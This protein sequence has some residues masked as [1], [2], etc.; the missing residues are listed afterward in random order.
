MFEIG[1]YPYIS[2][3]TET[4]GLYW[5]QN[6]MFG[7][8]LA[9]PDGQACYHDIRDEPERA[10][11]LNYELSAYKGRIIFHNASFDIK[12]LHSAGIYVP[13]EL[14]DDTVIRACLLDEHEMSYSLD[15][16][17]EKHLKRNK[18]NDIYPDLANIFGGRATRSVQMKNLHMAPSSLVGPYAIVDAVETLALWEW[19]EE[20]IKKQGIE[21]IIEFERRVMQP[22]IK[23]EMRGVRV[24]AAVAEKAM[25]KLTVEVEAQQAELNSLLKFEINVNSPKQ[26]KEAFNAKQDEGG[27]WLIDSGKWIPSTDSGAPSFDAESLR[28]LEGDRRADLIL[29]IRSTVKTRD[30]FLGGHILGHVVGDRVYP[31]INQNKG[32]DGGTGTGRLSYT[33]PAL[34]QI[35]S[36]NK[37]V[38]AIVKP[39]FLPDEGCDWVSLDMNSFEVRVF[40]HLVNNEMI[41]KAYSENE[42]MDLHQYVADLTG[43]PRN[44]TYSGQA[45]AKQLNLSMLFNSGNGAIAEKM[46][47]PW[48]WSSFA[49]KNGD[50]I[51]YKK[52]GP[53]AI[54]VIDE[55]HRKIPGVKELATRAKEIAESHGHINTKHGRRLRFPRKFKTYKASGLAIQ[56][57]AADISKEAWL[58]LDEMQPTMGGN[59]VM[60]VHDSF[61]LSIKKGTNA[62]KLRDEI[63]N[64]L[65]SV[66][67]WFRIP[68]V[69]DLNGTGASYWDAV[70]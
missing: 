54:A 66:V 44:A 32:D 58:L 14:A 51:K 2:L 13:I 17:L 35:P 64:E 11:D 41:N 34:Q 19:Q 7:F 38:A 15:S 55:Y 52:P 25:A 20:E 16:L 31:R 12:M 43:L 59:L 49:A 1:R 50:V 69:I 67:P 46:G 24:D 36:R 65:R 68:L 63:Q 26:V 70:K 57:T 60:S 9:A 28:G 39:A 8:S 5:P 40:A 61:E 10:G 21:S 3:D 62:A 47:M 29:A 42:A 4:N 18:K 22:I 45:N 37:R 56:A 30:T 33:E 48:E 53:E 6:R 27:N 23:A